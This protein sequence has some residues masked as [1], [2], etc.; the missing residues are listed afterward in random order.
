VPAVGKVIGIFGG[1]RHIG[2][3]DV[4]GCVATP[5]FE[6]PLRRA[7]ETRPNLPAFVDR[8]MRRYYPEHAWNP[9]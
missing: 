6:T 1:D 8:A 7:V 3:R 5:F 9:A 4:P 2:G